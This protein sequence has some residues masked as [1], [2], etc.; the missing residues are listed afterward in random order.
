MSK[1]RTRERQLAKL[2]ERRAAERRRKR[3]QRGVAAAVAI[4]VAVAGI[5]FGLYALTRVTKK[6]A[7]KPT[8][9]PTASVNPEVAKCGYATSQQQ[10]GPNGP[11]PPPT[12]MIDKAKKYV[13]TMKTSLGTFQIELMPNV[14]P[15][16]VNSFVYLA[17]R[18]YFDGLIFHRIAEDPPVIQGGDP[19]GTGSGG[20]GYSFVDELDNELGYAKG[21]VAMANSGPSTNGSQFFVMASTSKTLPH[22]YTIFGRVVKGL[23]VVEKIHS[24]PVNG[25]KPKKDVTIVKVTIKI[26]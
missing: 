8:P 17:Q 14:A 22:N 9:T 2:A 15:C 3:R 20:P 19:T 11:V 18:G 7:A 12:T 23:D 21:A 25:E 5:G 10:S 1:R 4:V 13:A 6:P 24:V 26:S 16:T